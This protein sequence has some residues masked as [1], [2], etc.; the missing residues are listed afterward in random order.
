MEDKKLKEICKKIRYEVLTSTT[1]AGSG[2]PTSCLSAVELSVALFFGGFFQAEDKFILSKGHAAPLLYSIYSVAGLIPSD[3]IY[4]LRKFGSPYEG[5]PTP[6]FP[7]VDVATGSL[8][9][10]LSVGV[11]MALGIRLRSKKDGIE[12]GPKVWVLLGDS[13]MAEGQVW[14]ALEIASYYKLNN[15]VAILDVNRLGQS[16]ETMLGWDLKTYAKRMEAF[17]WETIVVEDGHD[18]VEISQSL[19]KIVKTAT[20]N[21]PT[22]VIARTIKGKGASFLENKEG[23]HGK[24]LDKEELKIALKELGKIDFNVL[25]KIDN[26]TD[27]VS[28]SFPPG[29]G[30][31]KVASTLSG[32]LSPRHLLN[33]QVATREAYGDSLVELGEENPNIVVLDAEVGNS[34]YENKFQKKFPERFFQMFIAEQNMIGVALGL[35]KVGFLPFM[36]TLAAFL[37]RG[38]DQIRMAQYSQG[39]IKIVG[40]HCGVSIGADGPSQMGLEDIAM[41]RSVLKSVVFYPSDAVSTYKLTKVMADNQGIFYLRTT[42]GKTPIIYGED[43]EFKIGGCKV[44]QLKSQ[45]LKVK[46]S[47]KNSKVLLIAAGITLHESLKAQEELAKEGIEAIVIDCYSIKPL[48][49]VTIINYSKEIKNIIVVEDHYPAGGLGEAV[50]NVILGRSPA[51]AGRRLQNLDNDSGQARMTREIN[52]VHLAVRKI[53]CSGTPEELLRYEEIDS[54]A[55]ITSVKSIRIHNSKVK[56]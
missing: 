50:A 33:Y 8:G 12:T 53:P 23:W 24:A 22:I 32:S 28:D 46:S 16:R 36:S 18:L 11:G 2:H 48:D 45:K 6:R 14:E 55:I 52:F 15:L 49:K 44:H 26:L 17:G 41:M 34:T 51:T 30:S 20:N 42:R 40:S 39:N 4:K 25:S 10:G 54:Q 19:S 3:W 13:E 47:S 35:S 9:Q 31:Q 29:F 5:H 27:S 7:Y 38:F 21:K 56:S 37:T 43:E 1:N